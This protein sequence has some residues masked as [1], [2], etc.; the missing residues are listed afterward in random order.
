MAKENLSAAKEGKNDEFYTD[1]KDIQ[2]E[3]SHYSDKFKGK[4][5]FCNC[6]DP[7]ESN[8]VKYFL[9]NFNRLGLK[10]L[11][12][13]GYKT[14]PYGGQEIG[15][16]NTPYTLRVK[17]TSKYL[18]GTQKD[19]D[20]AG[21]KYFL[22]TEGNKIMTPLIGNNALDENGNQIKISVKVECL[23]DDGNTILTKAGKS[24]MKTVEQDLYYEAGDFRSDMSLALLNE[25]DIVVTNPPFSLFRE[26]VALLMKTNKK[27][28]II[29]NQNAITYKEIFP[30]IKNNEMWLGYGFSG[31]VGFFKSPYEDKASSSQHQKGK[32]RV[33]GVMWFTN[34][35]HD[36][37]HQMMPLDLGYTYYGHEDMYP[38]YDNYK[39][40]NVDKS[41][42][43]PCDYEDVIGVPITW[44]DKYCPEQFEIVGLAPER[45]TVDVLRIKKYVNSI[46]HNDPNAK[47]VKEGKKGVTE[48]GNKVN[49][50]P[51]ILHDTKPSK[52]P[53]YTSE[54]V[55]NKFIEVLYARILIKFT[56]DYINA[57]PEQFGNGGVK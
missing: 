21:A 39:G 11:I 28:L 3:L 33:S 12:A 10:E 17:D 41:N 16:M 45:E 6:D 51:A 24:K 5:V 30:L 35:D 50:G 47:L 36:K 15:V 54:T 1:L 32:I 29:G 31:N 52:Y 43:I 23:D 7:F 13:T 56:D 2:S 38:K 34:I 40:I 4:V 9:M 37:R 8:F 42:Q 44:L 27:F 55:P 46:Q 20:V 48:T 49:D 19:L 18:I 22:E 26:Y 25:A 53:Y 14:S 57:H